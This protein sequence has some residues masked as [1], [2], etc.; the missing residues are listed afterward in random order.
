MPTKEEI[1]KRTAEIILADVPEMVKGELTPETNLRTE[2]AIDSMGFI[3]IMSKLEGE[4]H[5]MVP[6]EEWDSIITLDDVAAAILR[7]VK[8]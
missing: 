4:Y 6:E 2:T 5:A 1:A 8:A 3:Y 7:H